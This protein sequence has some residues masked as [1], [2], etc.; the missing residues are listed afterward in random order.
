MGEGKEAAG[1]VHLSFSMGDRM[2]L[3]VNGL[4]RGLKQKKKAGEH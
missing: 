2:L 1:G 4:N 3:E